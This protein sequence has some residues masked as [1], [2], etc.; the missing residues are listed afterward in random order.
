[1]CRSEA[2]GHATVPPV[3][4][5]PYWCRSACPALLCGCFAGPTLVW[6]RAALLQRMTK[7]LAGLVAKSPASSFVMSLRHYFMGTL[8]VQRPFGR[9]GVA[10]ALH[11]KGTGWIPLSCATFPLVARVRK[12][13]Q[14]P[15]Q[16]LC[17]ARQFPSSR[18]CDTFPSIQ[19][20]PLSCRV[21]LAQRPFGRS[22]VA[23]ALH[24]KGTGWIGCQVPSQFLCHV[25]PALLHGRFTGPTAVRSIRCHS[26]TP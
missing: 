13:S 20:V 16:F 7:E 3:L 10:P 25:A 21:L 1:M 24:D 17:R 11:D 15:S 6:A 5:L 12:F 14:V 2:G 4:Q 26:S 9:S 19:P 23:P 8:L 22:G 18:E